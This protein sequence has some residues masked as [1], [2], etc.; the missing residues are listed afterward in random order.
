MVSAIFRCLMV[1]GLVG[2]LTGCRQGG[3][4]LP[5]GT[6]RPP[7]QHTNRIIV[8]DRDVRNTL[9]YINSVNK[10]L[11]G[12]QL[13]IQVNFQNRLQGDDV[14]ADV[15]FEF[16]DKNNM[17]MDKTQWMPTLFPASQVTMVQGSSLGGGAVKHVVLLKNLRTRNGRIIGPATDIFEVP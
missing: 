7:L 5:L 11:P 2:V 16:M 10:R 12:G 6:T 4:A 3:P 14:W 15:M 1:L 13:F 9:I 8:L 17:M